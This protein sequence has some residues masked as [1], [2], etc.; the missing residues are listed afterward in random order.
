MK[1]RYTRVAQ[2]KEHRISNPCC[3]GSNPFMGTR[4]V[5][6]TGKFVDAH[7][8]GLVRVGFAMTPNTSPL[9]P[10]RRVAQMVRAQ[11]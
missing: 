1:K 5:R 4:K 8:G 7:H 10:Y 11:V 6:V 9:P 2:W 3:E